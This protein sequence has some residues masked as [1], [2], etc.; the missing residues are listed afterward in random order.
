MIANATMRVR[1]VTVSLRLVRLAAITVGVMLG[2]WL[3][4]PLIG[5]VHPEGFTGSVAA[6]ALHLNRDAL[7]NFDPL[8]PLNTEYFG[9]T[10][11]GWV[12]ALAGLMKTGLSS[13]IAM[14]LLTWVSFAALC[15][16][17]LQLVRRW[18]GAPLLL[19]VAAW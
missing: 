16:A 2:A 13:L 4:L 15:S 19:I 8:Q 18:T 1:G 5:P 3:L 14:R 6:L 10:K 11:L 9:L 12:L 17:S 7:A